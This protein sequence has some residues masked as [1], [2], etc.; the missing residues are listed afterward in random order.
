MDKIMDFKD[1]DRCS[2]IFGVPALNSNNRCLVVTNYASGAEWM[3]YPEVPVEIIGASAGVMIEDQGD[4]WFSLV[5]TDEGVSKYLSVNK[6]DGVI[7]ASSDSVTE[8]E[9]FRLIL[10]DGDEN[11][12]RFCM[13][14]KTGRYVGIESEMD[15]FGDR[16]YKAVAKD[17]F[18]D[19]RWKLSIYAVIDPWGRYI[20]P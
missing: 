9:L 7:H 6:N 15:E 2:I 1:F 8:K 17:V 3:T 4:G 19:E 10:K 13:Y 16:L 14:S 12:N 11:A 20:Q 18:P 5:S